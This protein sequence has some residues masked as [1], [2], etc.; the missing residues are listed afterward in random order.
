MFVTRH[1]SLEMELVKWGVVLALAAA[2]AL[3]FATN[4]A[5]GDDQSV[6]PRLLPAEVTE[7]A[8]PM[9]EDPVAE[10]QSMVV[11]QEV[12]DEAVDEKYQLAVD[13]WRILQLHESHPQAA[14]EAWDEVILP[15]E[16]ERW[17][18]VAS[19]AVH[20]QLGD[21]ARAEDELHA[22]RGWDKE[23]P[24]VA[25]VMGKVRLA[26]A[27]EAR[28]W[29]DSL[30]KSK[31]YFV[32][33][34]QDDPYPRT[35]YR[36][37]ALMEFRRAV[38][39]AESFSLD[40]PLMDVWWVMPEDPSQGMPVQSPSLRDLVQAIGVDDYVGDAHQQLGRLYVDYGSLMLAERHL[41]V[42]S[43]RGIGVSDAYRNLAQRY[44]SVD[45]HA[46]AARAYFKSIKH[47]GGVA[48]PLQRVLQNLA[49]AILDG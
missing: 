48:D 3:G 10:V 28:E 16:L 40:E 23:N 25:Y 14:L 9:G 41:D 22:A 21:I 6:K 43:D 32:S 13:L 15:C 4:A 39:S 38:D 37:A 17:R 26:Q 2:L 36:L 34:T 24:V 42:A 12:N 1:T 8:R 11:D 29:Y 7:L 35:T 45:L 31:R 19:G 44:E 47:G 20:L 27:A 46:D 30:G 18:L 49:D 5:S 33:H